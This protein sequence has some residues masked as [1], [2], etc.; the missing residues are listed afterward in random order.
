MKMMYSHPLLSYVEVVAADA[1]EQSPSIGSQQERHR[2]CTIMRP[3]VD[4]KQLATT[5]SLCDVGVSSTLGQIAQQ[6][7]SVA[8][9]FVEGSSLCLGGAG[10][11]GEAPN[12]GVPETFTTLSRILL[13]GISIGPVGYILSAVVVV[14]VVVVLSLMAV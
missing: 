5:N 7:R 14:G 11:V 6:K 1:V 9:T 3:Q 2:C 12:A 8:L 4:I 13:V 10:W